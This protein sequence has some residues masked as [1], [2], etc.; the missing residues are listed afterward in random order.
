MLNS[1]IVS[2]VLILI[3]RMNTSSNLFQLVRS[4]VKEKCKMYASIRIKKRAEERRRNL[5]DSDYIESED[6]RGMVLKMMLI[7]KIFHSIR[8]YG[9][10]SIIYSSYSVCAY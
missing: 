1:Q 9:A 6:A 2:F 5:T 7:M 3:C 4:R 8:K 10:C